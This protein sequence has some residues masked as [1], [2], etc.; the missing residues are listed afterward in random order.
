MALFAGCCAGKWRALDRC[1]GS[2]AFFFGSEL[3]GSL[4]G[5]NVRVTGPCSQSG[6]VV[7]QA[8]PQKDVINRST[9]SLTSV[10][11]HS[12]CGSHPKGFGPFPA[13]QLLA[14]AWLM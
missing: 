14:E 1:A 9:K 3:H 6:G 10:V 7:V 2:A 12:D 5:F 11:K 4:M 13:K 8:P